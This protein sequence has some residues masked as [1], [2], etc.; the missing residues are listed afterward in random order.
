M[1]AETRNAAIFFSMGT[2][3]KASASL[4]DFEGGQSSEGLGVVSRGGNNLS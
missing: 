3:T 1:V 4:T 2:L